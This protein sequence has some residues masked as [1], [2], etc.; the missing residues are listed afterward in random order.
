MPTILP[1]NRGDNQLRQV[2]WLEVVL[3]LL[4]VLLAAWLLLFGG[5]G[6]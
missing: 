5:N 2:G 1:S 4:G 6:N 3:I